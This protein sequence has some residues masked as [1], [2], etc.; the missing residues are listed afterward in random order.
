MSSNGVS[1]GNDRFNSDATNWDSNPIV[2][3]ATRLAFQTLKPI[4]Q[5]LSASSDSG[6]D[7]LEV[8]CGTGLL[9]LQLAPLVKDLVAV[10]PAPGL[11]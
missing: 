1:T 8:G 2:Q 7:V 11:Y 5:Q 9:T 6:L 10:D 4:I 3:E